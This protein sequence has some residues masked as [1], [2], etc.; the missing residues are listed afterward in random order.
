VL[1]GVSRLT[2]CAA[3]FRGDDDDVAARRAN[4]AMRATRAAT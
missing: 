3:S 4:S 2:K 1:G